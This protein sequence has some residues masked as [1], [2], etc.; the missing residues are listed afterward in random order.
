ME[1][2]NKKKKK[3]EWS[4]IVTG[5]TMLSFGVYGIWCGIEYY[6]LSKL[7]IENNA[8]PPDA[9]LAVTCVTT[10]LASLLS[11]C[12]YNGIL[13]NSLNKN[14]LTIDED[15]IVKPLMNGDIASEIVDKIMN[16]VV[17]KNDTD[18]SFDNDAGDDV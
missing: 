14:G 15:G 3:R 11:Y 7:A 17:N 4:K 1:K 6:R 13:K 16:A 8:T 2:K 18:I 5:L 12:L 9:V 10:V